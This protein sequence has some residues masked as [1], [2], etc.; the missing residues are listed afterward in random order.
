MG[1]TLLQSPGGRNALAPGGADRYR[2]AV[3][4]DALL[5]ALNEAECLPG[6]LAELRGAPGASGAPLRR[7]VVVDNGS[8]DETYRVARA[9]GA[10]ALH[11][12]ERGYGAACLHGLAFLRA[13]PPDVV[14]FLDADGAD[15][16][17]DLPALLAPIARA[18]AELVIGSRVLGEA[19]AGA[20]TPVQIFGNA[21]SCR[22]VD[23]LWGVRFTDL[24]PF[25]AVTWAALDRLAME[26]RNF[27]WTVE[28]QARAARLGLA[29]AEVPVRYRR[30]RAGVSKVAGT[31]EGSA[32]AGAKIL[33]TIGREAL[34]G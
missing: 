13:D 14:V 10:V 31:I 28:M 8:R 33:Y 30:R 6:V 27:G 29:C 19:E 24:G 9:A 12:R 20:L 26:D 18:E 1:G 25:R 23:L 16:P 21:L 34:R 17:A 22:L 2:A 11:C 15:D 7:I 5:P 3:R 32:R 4:V